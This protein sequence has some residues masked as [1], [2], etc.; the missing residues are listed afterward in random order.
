MRKSLVPSRTHT[1]GTYHQKDI[2]TIVKVRIDDGLA[3]LAAGWSYCI[4]M[5][6]PLAVLSVTFLGVA[7]LSSTF[8]VFFIP[9]ASIIYLSIVAGYCRAL[10]KGEQVP[11][12]DARVYRSAPLWFVAIVAGA[13][14][15][16]LRV[17]SEELGVSGLPASWLTS[18]DFGRPDLYFLG[19]VILALLALMAFCTA[20]AL[21]ILKDVDAL[22]AIRLSL[23][24]S[25]KNPIPMLAFIALAGALLFVASLPLGAGLIVA[26]PVAACGLFKAYRQIF[27]DAV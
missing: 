10:D 3:W 2:P 13:V 16:S 21:V 11:Y 15:L 25:L 27:N 24:G 23:L 8:G 14:S 7:V 6:A 20:P 18:D 1:S 4:R 19:I 9:A 22:Q 17:L 26:M 5:K 12:G